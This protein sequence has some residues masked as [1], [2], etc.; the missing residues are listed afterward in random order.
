MN[1]VGNCHKLSQ[2]FSKAMSTAVL[3]Q[4]RRTLTWAP[5]GTRQ[6]WPNDSFYHAFIG[7]HCE[8]VCWFC[9]CIAFSSGRVF[10]LDITLGNT[11]DWRVCQKVKP[12]PQSPIGSQDSEYNYLGPYFLYQTC[13]FPQGILQGTNICLNTSALPSTPLSLSIHAISP[14]SGC[15]A[16]FVERGNHSNGFHHRFS[17]RLSGPPD[18]VTV[19]AYAKWKQAGHHCTQHCQNLVWDRIFKLVFSSTAQSHKNS[20]IVKLCDVMFSSA[21][22]YK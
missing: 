19:I 11:Q 5:G 14:Y 16:F 17:S 13:I 8:I 20:I 12:Y 3:S 10:R 9:L 6:S 15:C 18:W 22:S 7:K 2:K 4:D 21:S 1:H